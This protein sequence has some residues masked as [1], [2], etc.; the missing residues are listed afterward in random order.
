MRRY[1][2]SSLIIAIVA[3]I[4][5]GRLKMERYVEDF[6]WQLQVGKGGVGRKTDV[7]RAARSSVG[8]RQGDRRQSMAV[9]RDR[10]CGG[11]GHSR[12]RARAR[13]SRHHGPQSMVASILRRVLKPRLIAV[14]VGVIATAS[15]ITGYLFNLVIR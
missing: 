1:V 14:F 3:G 4:I 13:I 11:R 6:V 10:H 2:F 7:A 5:I 8:V 12:L 9:C 15:I